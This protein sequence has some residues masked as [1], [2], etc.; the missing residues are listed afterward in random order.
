MFG[1]QF[2]NDVFMYT[3]VPPSKVCF[4]NRVEEPKIYIEKIHLHKCDIE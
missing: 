1:H 3:P 2:T 4:G